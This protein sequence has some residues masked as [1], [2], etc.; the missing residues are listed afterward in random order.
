MIAAIIPR[1]AYS[2]NNLKIKEELINNLLI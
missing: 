1:T 2:L